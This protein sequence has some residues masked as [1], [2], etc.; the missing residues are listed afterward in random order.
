MPSI[1]LREISNRPRG[2]SGARYLRYRID[3]INSYWW[4]LT[5]TLPVQYH[6][7]FESLWDDDRKR[8]F[9]EGFEVLGARAWSRQHLLVSSGMF[10]PTR[11]EVHVEVV[12]RR[13]IDNEQW[14]VVA[15]PPVATNAQTHVDYAYTGHL[16]RGRVPPTGPR[17]ADVAV[18]Q[19]KE[20]DLGCNWH[21][22]R[23]GQPRLRRTL[24]LGAAHEIGHMLGLQHPGCVGNEPSCYGDPNERSGAASWASAAGCRLPTTS[25]R[26][27][28]WSARRPP[29]GRS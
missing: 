5:A 6:I 11:T 14:H 19:L 3:R 13:A 1:N 24:Q 22:L 25:G 21:H 2:I 28:S 17:Y 23:S 26:D 29:A 20:E 10:G 18:V 9:R 12:R 16:P 15:L 27:A 8:A 7:A 4:K